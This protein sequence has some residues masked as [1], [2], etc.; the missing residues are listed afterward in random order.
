MDSGRGSEDF[1]SQM[2]TP[3]T[4]DSTSVGTP[5][6]YFGVPSHGTEIKVLVE[7]GD[8]VRWGG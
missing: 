1:L 3:Q 8:E 5:D 2:E 6:Q 7:D 4:I